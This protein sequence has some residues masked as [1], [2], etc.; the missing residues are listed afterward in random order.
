M[1]LPE[2]LCPLCLKND[3]LP[4]LSLTPED[5]VSLNVGYE[6]KR[7]RDALQGYENQLIYSQ[8]S[9]GMIYCKFRWPDTILSQVYEQT[10]DHAMSVRKIFRLERRLY[11]IRQWENVLRIFAIHGKEYVEGL[12]VLDF[13]CGWG[14]SLDVYRGPGVETFG[15]ELDRLKIEGALK[16]GNRILQTQEEL[17]ALEPVDV[18]ILNAV[19]EHV[20][21]GQD[22]MRLAY[23]KLKPGGVLVLSTM[24]FRP[25]FIRKNINNS[26]LGKP[27]LSQHF[28]PVEHVNIYDYFTVQRTLEIFGFKSF[29]SWNVMQWAALPVPYL[30]NSRLWIR[31][32]NQIENLLAHL[33]QNKE[34][35]ITV[36]ALKKK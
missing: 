23:N 36:Y 21:E 9:C 29:A 27:L 12:R 22:L 17:E 8:C 28:N 26:A 3:S 15:F 35:A 33:F 13:G 31:A 20:Q 4:I 19:I 6:L 24:D 25:T 18:F 14:D 11:L 7:F 2:R 30:R 10:I 34:R 32:L 1:N 5:V 16:R